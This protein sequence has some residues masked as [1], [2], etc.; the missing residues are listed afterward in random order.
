MNCQTNENNAEGSFELV[1]KSMNKENEELPLVD[2][3]NVHDFITNKWSGGTIKCLTCNTIILDSS[4][5]DHINL[6]NEV[7][8]ITEL[9]FEMEEY[10]FA[11][12]FCGLR[13]DRKQTCI[14]HIMQHQVGSSENV[15]LASSYVCN[16]CGLEFVSQIECIEHIETH[17]MKSYGSDNNK[18][19]SECVNSEADKDNSISVNLDFGSLEVHCLLCN[20]MVHESYIQ[21]HMRLHASGKLKMSSKIPIYKFYIYICKICD[22]KPFKSRVRYN[23][24][25]DNHSNMEASPPVIVKCLLCEG[26]MEEQDFIEHFKLHATARL[27]ILEDSLFRAELYDYACRKCSK[28]YEARVSYVKHLYLHAYDKE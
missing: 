2:E 3:N 8:S 11:C 6:H 19:T 12:N 18:N 10:I 17:E 26:N 13:F 7:G 9:N 27:P 16:I 23:K 14:N 1:I 4:I 28:V 25:R 15:S 20:E 5:N 21:S 22:L 24:H